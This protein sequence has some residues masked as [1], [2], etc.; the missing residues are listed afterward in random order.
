MYNFCKQDGANIFL[1]DPYVAYWE[2]LNLK[3]NSEIDLVLSKKIDILI[4]STSHDEYRDSKIFV[5]Q[6]LKKDR[7]FILDTVG[8]FSQ[9]E[10]ETLSTKHN[11]KVIGRGDL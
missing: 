7:M 11:L 10:I 6:I 5:N 3:V 4:I 2:E 9:K 8:L 1:H